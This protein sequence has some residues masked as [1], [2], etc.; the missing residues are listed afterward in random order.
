MTGKHVRMWTTFLIVLSTTGNSVLANLSFIAGSA[1]V[2]PPPFWDSSYWH[3][4]PGMQ[5]GFP[6]TVVS[7]GPY[8]LKELEAAV[9]HYYGDSTA[10]FSVNVDNN[11]EPGDAIATTFM[12]GIT[13][14]PQVVN[15]TFTEEVIL[16]SDTLYWLVGKADGEVNW[17]LGGTFGP[18]A[19]EGERSTWVVQPNRNLAAYA[20]LGS[21]V[22]EPATIL[23]LGL[24]GLALVCRKRE[25]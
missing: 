16:Q 13:T 21:P 12:T 15:S 22:P 2:S 7:G 18:V 19:F 17:N 4:E 8:I 14:T 11:G 9:F 10:S 5:K 1:G 3:I 20:I 24:G 6:L 23:L 25:I